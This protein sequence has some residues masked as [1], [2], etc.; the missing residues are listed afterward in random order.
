M[1]L[2][3]GVEICETS[4]AR[5]FGSWLRGAVPRLRAE[6][7]FSIWRRLFSIWSKSCRE[8]FVLAEE[9]AVVVEDTEMCCT[10]GT[11]GQQVGVQ[12]ITQVEDLKPQLG[13][14]T[15]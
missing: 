12:P 11:G 10:C 15:Q 1:L 4:A 9:V 14:G 5:N 7:S 2:C 6:S 8:S 13:A 3:S